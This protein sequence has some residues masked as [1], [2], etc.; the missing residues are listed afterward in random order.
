MTHLESA[1]TSE[2]RQR[3][4]GLAAGLVAMLTTGLVGG[5]SFA[6][7]PLLEATGL[8]DAH[9]LPPAAS[10][11]F[12][13]P[14]I[15]PAPA[16]S[17]V[18]SPPGIAEPEATLAATTLAQRLDAVPR[19]FN[20][21]SAAMV[22]DSASGQLLYANNPAAM[23]IPASNMKTLTMLG[24]LA[25]L[26]GDH[27][28]STTVSSPSVGMIVLK[29]GGDPYL[30]SI[31]DPQ[32][33]AGPTTAE[34]ARLTAQALKASGQTRVTLG[35]DQ[36]AFAGPDWAPTWPS[37]YV[38]QVTRI[39]ALMV[40][41]GR[42]RNADGT[43]TSPARSATP[44]AAAAGIFATQLSTHG[45][46]VSG[47]ITAR[48]AGGAELAKVDSLPLEQL[49][50]IAMVASDN[51]ATEMILRQVAISRGVEPSFAG[52]TRALQQVLT[53]LKVWRQGAQL[54]D[55]SGLS[56]S[57]LVNAEMLAAAW[58]TIASTERLRTLVTAT[59]VAR[60]SGTLSDRFLIDESAAG[61]GRV[62]AKTGTLSEVSSLSG[63]TVTTSGQ[64]VIIVLIVNQSQ[65]DWWARAWIDTAAAVVSECGCP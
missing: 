8:R 46:T 24:A 48:T 55:G 39:S 4:T 52:G 34:L 7:A 56:R 25:S 37:G 31:P 54:H 63:W 50:T 59:P 20:G 60:V 1:N 65:D 49:A 18:I 38:N 41:G 19:K 26:P 5:V 58:R 17:V 30:R 53:E 64:S 47:N 14:P 16:P 36:S 21:A 9:A 27:V 13:A 11:L 51:T 44:A 40:D 10:T 6:H 35:F 61:R 33:P 43:I 45:I 28:L 29:G 62:H 2:P 3:R 57:N 22:L 42:T 32:Q 23:M 15:P 12:P